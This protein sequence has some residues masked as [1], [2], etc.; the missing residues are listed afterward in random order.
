MPSRTQPTSN[1]TSLRES[2]RSLST[3][4]I[5]SRKFASFMR[6]SI[7]WGQSNLP[8]GLRLVVGV[9]FVAVGVFGFLPIAGFWMIPIGLGLIALDIPPLHRRLTRWLA[10]HDQG[11]KK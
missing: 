8:K 6:Q 3:M 9:V 11:R 7:D 1:D 2:L 10:E 4:G 5:A